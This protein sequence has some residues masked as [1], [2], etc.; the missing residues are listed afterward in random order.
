MLCQQILYFILVKDVLDK[1]FGPIMDQP[2]LSHERN[3]QLSLITRCKLCTDV[4]CQTTSPP[5]PP[6]NF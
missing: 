2:P 3:P 1:K 5:P 4:N 6:G